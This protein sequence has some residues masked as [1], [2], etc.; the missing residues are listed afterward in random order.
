MTLTRLTG[1]PNEGYTVIT[2]D[3]FGYPLPLT[4]RPPYWLPS[5]QPVVHRFPMTL[6]Q[7]RTDDYLR[8][9]GGLLLEGPLVGTTETDMHLNAEQL[10]WYVQRAAWLQRADRA[11]LAL[12]P[13]SDIELKPDGSKSKRAALGVLLVAAELRW[14][15]PD[16][17]EVTG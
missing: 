13:G 1:D 10:R 8:T 6:R 9:A 3:S 7:T 4:L 5:L 2:V 17:R 14:I 12:L 11:S 16:G 15:G